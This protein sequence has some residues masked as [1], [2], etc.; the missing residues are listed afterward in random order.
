MHIR[1]REII[2]LLGGAV[3]AW[4][5]AARA[6]ASAMPVVGFLGSRAPGDDP[7][8][9]A[10][11]RLG[12]KESGRI[13]NE[14]VVIEYHFADNQ[15]ERL[16][17]MAA[18][19]VRRK[20]AVIC[21]NGPAAKAAKAATKTIPIVFTV[22]FDPVELGLVASLNRPG[23]NITG[24]SVLDVELGPKR[25]ELLHELIPKA[26]H[27]AALVNP[28]DR[29]RAAAVSKN[30][31]AAAGTL[32]LQLQVVYASTDR[33]LETV[34]ANLVQQ[35]LGALV[36]GGD[37]F[38]NSRGEHIGALSVRYA[39]PTIFQFR[40]F[41][42]GGGLVSYGANLVDSYRQV[43]IYAGRILNGEKP[44]DLP[45]QQATKAELILNLKTAKALGLIVP[46]TLIGRAD[47]VIE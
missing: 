37:P 16:P 29:A 18:D 17:E 43:G 35:H 2:T 47:E 42:A 34:F 36:I 10:A 1:R 9:L 32:G 21:A 13:E 22:G 46:N 7:Q 24:L 12:L 11:F 41:A 39:V 8:L 30:L 26:I 5:L 38:F 23:G 25:L 27:V 40:Q 33:D 28:A 15:Y 45:V 6:Q 4:P 3:A 44:A 14:S 31:L 20:V 19:F